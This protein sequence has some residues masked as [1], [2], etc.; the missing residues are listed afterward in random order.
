MKC[1]SKTR[2]GHEQG[3][4]ETAVS[5][6]HVCAKV[7]WLEVPTFHTHLT[8]TYHNITAQEKEVTGCTPEYS[9]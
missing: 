7:F 3:E 8:V 9:I 4:S 6:E 5:E 2:A 1:G